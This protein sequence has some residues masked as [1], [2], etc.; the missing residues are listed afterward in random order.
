MTFTSP[1]SGGG[2]LSSLRIVTV[3]TP[4]S[5]VAFT[6]EDSS[7]VNVSLGSGLEPPSISTS[8]FSDVSPGAYVSV[9]EAAE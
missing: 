8:M 5:I 9:P 2:G 6:G 7:I 3:M 4:R 1:G